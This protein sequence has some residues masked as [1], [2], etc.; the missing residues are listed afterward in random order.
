MGLDVVAGLTLAAIAVPEQMATARLGGFAPQVGFFAF[1]AATLAFAA[2]GSNRQL[3]VGADFDHHAHLRRQPGGHGGAGSP[4]YADLAASLALIVGAFLLLGGLLKLGWIADLLSRPVIIGFLAGISL[5]I[6]LSQAP[7]VLGLPEGAGDVYHRMA[8]LWLQRGGFNILTLAIGLGVLAIT[9]AAERL[10][11]RIPG[12]LIA[13]VG[14]TM[15]TAGLG[16]E[17]RGVA[18]LG[19][20]TAACRT[21]HPAPRPGKRPAAGRAGDGDRPGGDGADRGG[22]PLLR[23]RRRRSGRGRRLYRRRRRQ[24]PGRLRR[25]LPVNASPPRTASVA[26]SGGRT[27][28]AGLTAALAV[29]ALAASGR[30]CWRTCRPRR[31]AGSCCSS[32]CGSSTPASFSTSCAAPG[33]SSPWRR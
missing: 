16:L 15:A 8:A 21:Q 6:V 14:A 23:S 26:A 3:S 1:I 19:H 31:W 24:R 10:D 30:P 2:F 4:H 25:R 33:P 20:V 17:R 28:F 11:A 22:D 12:A 13:L 27:Q 18:V 7:T 32:P 29:L 5:H 9:W